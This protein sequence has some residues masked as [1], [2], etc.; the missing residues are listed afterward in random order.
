M[1]SLGLIRFGFCKWNLLQE[2]REVVYSSCSLKH[3]MVVSLVW[4]PELPFRPSSKLLSYQR[5]LLC[6]LTCVVI[7]KNPKS[8]FSWGIDCFV[9]VAIIVFS[10]WPLWIVIMFPFFT[11]ATRNLESNLCPINSKYIGHYNIFSVTL[12]LI[13]VLIFIFLSYSLPLLIYTIFFVCA[14]PCKLP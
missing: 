4:K 11:L 10:H 1:S 5:K 12:G 2:F 6:I 14:S 9:V 13:S 8:Y 3:D 7:I